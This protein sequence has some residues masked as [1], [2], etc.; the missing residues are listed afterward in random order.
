MGANSTWAAGLE[1]DHPPPLSAKVNSD[2]DVPQLTYEPSWGVAQLIKHR[3]NST[4]LLK[5]RRLSQMCDN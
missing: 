3:Y 5:T 1:V 4:L 2:V